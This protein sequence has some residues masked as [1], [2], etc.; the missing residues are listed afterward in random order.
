MIIVSVWSASGL[1]RG[2]PSSGG[3]FTGIEFGVMQ[4]GDGKDPGQDA[5]TIDSIRVLGVQWK[6]V[7]I[8]WGDFETM[9]GR[10]ESVV[11]AY[12]NAGI[13][14]VIELVSD[15]YCI[16]QYQQNCKESKSVE[17]YSAWIKNVV[18]RYS[19]LGVHNWQI[20]NHANA[21][22]HF[23]RAGKQVGPP[24]EFARILN[25][26]YDA[27]KEADSV[28][29][30]SIQLGSFAEEK[31][32]DPRD[33]IQYLTGILKENGRFDVLWVV[34]IGSLL[35]NGD[36]RLREA[37]ALMTEYWGKEKPIWS[38]TSE[39]GGGTIGGETQSEEY[40]A[41]MLEKKAQFLREQ[42]V[43]TM[44]WYKL[45]DAFDPNE[46]PPDFPGNYNQLG[47]L[48]RNDFSPKL[49]YYRYQEVIQRTASTISRTSSTSTSSSVA[50]TTSLTSPT[51]P[52]S[53]PAMTLG[54]AVAGIVLT[55]TAVILAV[56]A[57]TRKR[58]RPFKTSVRSLGSP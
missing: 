47:G 45:R 19:G 50:T 38:T 6:D 16:S 36:A 14:I 52:P 57:A 33:A 8:K 46:P 26:A 17:Q 2:F 21:P 15:P 7:S 13:R 24:E 42:G 54:S 43:S 30:V 58:R 5:Q 22:R 27:V 10:W 53:T 49:A 29:E 28:G 51:T 35:E 40:Q 32:D 48:M 12:Q 31:K 1:A 34:V 3:N 20:E 23:W 25:V 55:G 9:P 44:F 41:E 37:R 56:I 11:G 4:S 39:W 18:F